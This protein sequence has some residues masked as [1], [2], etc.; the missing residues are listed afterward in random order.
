MAKKTTRQDEYKQLTAQRDKLTAKRDTAQSK[1]SELESTMSTRIL[2]GA[3]A[4]AL[5]REHDSAQ[6]EILAYNNALL[7][8]DTQIKAAKVAVDNVVR[9]DMLASADDDAKTLRTALLDVHEAHAM[10]IAR[11]NHANR[12]AVALE[13][14]L[15]QIPGSVAQRG[16]DTR[17][18]SLSSTVRGLH[19]EIMHNDFK[20]ERLKL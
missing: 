11:S 7:L 5:A 19:V 9:V 6:R 18:H 16:D 2:A 4:A 15:H 14:K 8:L 13:A 12:L 1:A 3:D 10:L 17:H 20:I